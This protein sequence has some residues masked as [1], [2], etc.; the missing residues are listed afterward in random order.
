MYLMT[1]AKTG[2]AAVA[3]PNQLNNVSYNYRTAVVEY[4]GG[5]ASI[6]SNVPFIEG[7]ELTQMQAGEIWEVQSVFHSRP[8]ESLSEKQ[9]RL[10]VMFADISNAEI[11]RLQNVLGYWGHSRTVP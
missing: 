7:T 3:I 4:Q 1:R 2:A 10:D 5:T 6:V 11:A 8:G 9:A